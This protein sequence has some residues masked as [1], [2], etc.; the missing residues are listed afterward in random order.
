MD[1]ILSILLGL[2]CLLAAVTFIGHGIWVVVAAVVRQI[3]G[4]S[5]TQVELRHRKPCPQ[6]GA[7]H[8]LDRGKCTVCGAVPQVAPKSP[9]REEL[10]ATARQLKR[11]QTAGNIS[12]DQYEQLAAVLARELG[13]AATQQR[14]SRE[15]ADR[16]NTT[17][18]VPSAPQ[19]EEIIAA[20]VIDEPAPARAASVLAVGGAV[21]DTR[22]FARPST[23]GAATFGAGP[24][25]T[26][27]TENPLQHAAV[28]APAEP[29][30]PRPKL[31]D[32]LQ[33]F[34]EESNIRWG[35]ILAGFFIVVSSIGLVISLQSTL[36]RIPYFPALLFTGFTVAFHGAGLYT[37]KRWNLHAI[38]R[39]I[40]VISMLLVPLT[41]SA[42]VLMSRRTVDPTTSAPPI[43][44]WV[45]L[46]IGSA[47]LTWV[48]YT[49][50]RELVS[51]SKWRLTIGVI[52]C[53]LVQVLVHRLNL[54]SIDFWQ[55]TALGSLPLG[56]FLVASVGQ[57]ILARKW[58]S[59][60]WSRAQ[61]TFIVLGVS[62]FAFA[63]AMAMLL[64]KA[65]PRW[66]A[67]ARLTPIFSLAAGSATALG[68]LLHRRTTARVMAGVRTAGTVIWLLGGTT[69]LLMV[70]LAWP[71]P[72]LLLAVG[73]VNAVLLTTL[74]L[75]A[76]LSLLFAPAV[77]C[78]ALSALMGFH[79]AQGRFA[80]VPVDRI[81]RSVVEALL[82][83]RSSLILLVTA[84]SAT[85][86]AE[87]V[88]RFRSLHDARVILE[89]SG[90]L[91]ILGVLVALFAGFVPVSGWT[92]DRNFAAPLL[93]L[94]AGAFLAAAPF[95]RWPYLAYAG[96]AVLFAALVQGLVH[97][98][99]LREF[100]GERGWLPG[101]SLAAALVGHSLVSS[102]VLACSAL[103][104]RV[105]AAA[106]TSDDFNTRRNFIEP[107]AAGTVLSV[108]VVVPLLIVGGPTRLYES[109]ILA[110]LAALGWLAVAIV[111]RWKFA[112]SGL[113]AML[114][115]APALAIAAFCF[116]RLG[117]EWYRS[118]D[119]VGLQCLA[120]A[121]GA[122]T[123]AMTRRA[124]RKDSSF[125]EL[126]H[127]DWPSVDQIAIGG[128]TL[129]V[130]LLAWSLAI[131]SIGWELGF[132]SAPPLWVSDSGA[133]TVSPATWIAV[134]VMAVCIGLLASVVER[135]RL[136]SLLGF[137]IATFALV[138]GGA[139]PWDSAVAVAS[140]TRWWAGI[141][142]VVWAILFIS[143]SPLRS[144]ALSIG[145]LR[146]DPI[147]RPTAHAA[148]G[149]VPILFGALPILVLTI[150]PVAQSFQG[151]A[152]RGPEP[153]SFFSQIGPTA[154]YAVPLLAI[155]AVF[156]GY[157][158]RERESAFALAGSAVF[159]LAVNL[160]FIL[161]VTYAPAAAREVR[162][163]ECL[164]WNT[165]AAAGFAVVWLLLGA[166]MLPKGVIF[167]Q[168]LKGRRA[169]TLAGLQVILAA[170][171]ATVIVGWAAVSVIV[172]PQVTTSE[173]T[174]LGGLL[175][176]L[177]IG[178]ACAAAA[179]LVMLLQLHQR[180]QLTNLGF[181]LLTGGVALAA[182]TIDRYDSGRT[183]LAYHT[184]V[185]GWLGLLALA[186]VAVCLRARIQRVFSTREWISLG[187]V[188]QGIVTV[189]GLLL[190][191][192]AVR[193]N[194]AD[195]AQPWWSFAASVGVTTA[196]TIL[197]IRLCRQPYA[198][199][200]IAGAVLTVVLFW[201][202][203]VHAP[204]RS[205][206]GSEATPVFIEIVTLSLI[207]AAGFWQAVEIFVQVK[208]SRSLDLHF[209]GPR[210]HVAV[211]T[212]ALLLY[213]AWRVL[214]AAFGNEPGDTLSFYEVVASVAVVAL[215]ATLFSALWDR[216]SLL[217][218]PGLF[219]WLGIVALLAINLAGPHVPNFI[220]RI[221]LMVLSTGVVIAIAGQSWSYGANLSLIGVRLGVSDP[222]GGLKRTERW[223]PAIT[224]IAAAG[225]L[226]LSLPFVLNLPRDEIRIAVAF[227]PA[228]AAWG[229]ACLAD[230]ERRPMFRLQALLLA[231]VS[232][233]YLSWAQLGTEMSEAMWLTRVFRLLMV[234]S[235]LTFL[236]GLALP[237]WLLTAG[238]WHRVTR[239]A[240][241][242]AGAAAIA[243]FVAVLVLEIV[244][245]QPG[246]GAPVDYLQVLA[247]AVVLM[248]LIAGMISMALLPG[249]DPFLLSEKGKQAYVYAALATAALLFA[250]LYVCR[251]M[252]F[253]AGLLP[254]WPLIVMAIAFLGAGGGELFARYRLTVL[255]EPLTRVSSMLPL[256]P[257]LGMWIVA[258]KET[259]YALVLL[260]VGVLYLMLSVTQ[261]SWASL[262][263]AAVAANGALWSVLNRSGLELLSNPQLWIIPP[264]L[265]VLIAAHLNR[266]RLPPTALTSIRYA[267]VLLIYVSS[268]SE[269]FLRG[270]ATSLWPA[271]ILATLSVAGAFVGMML[272]IR[273][274]LYLGASFALISLITMVAH[275][276]Q[277]INH[278]WPW[279][280]FGVGMGIAILVLFGIFEKQREEVLKLIARLREW[281]Q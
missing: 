209:I 187:H 213:F 201:S 280:A 166:R 277:A 157:A 169:A 214:S 39:V 272:R 56:C 101:N 32:M 235:V 9:L 193:G 154:S 64:M 26:A 34:L 138:A 196:A 156:L 205:V 125:S 114:L 62:L 82:M 12:E 57:L 53:S 238:P 110:A 175:S 111:A 92:Q 188:A 119:H 256:L 172:E 253:D 22:E 48:A 58:Q 150:L 21:R 129:F 203:P 224:L 198:Y 273:A 254:Y 167:N 245:F 116:H 14:D 141:Y 94:Y 54:Q 252:W 174:V 146:W 91:A 171:G 120:V 223:L 231:G 123:W 33:G 108:L 126:F 128:A 178:L 153:G 85:A 87:V 260:V 160:A 17:V 229:L 80:D 159:Q 72:E 225:T 49:S 278:V 202:A 30:P 130:A 168:Q 218:L 140:A 29:V 89:T 137:A 243:A 7:A 219:G 6:C 266:R 228:A 264:A 86:V 185:G 204:W 51:V 200:S 44:F 122:A 127:A 234:L 102:A 109:T 263:A 77:L 215:G 208:R 67:A 276:A 38:S 104:R 240:G 207:V 222:V 43:L 135:V 27:A 230:D 236:Y 42:A 255:A 221:A 105:G 28:S 113:Q 37:L 262:L 265:S 61:P 145:W 75:A 251:P 18:S 216:R 23:A 40:L 269:I 10:L 261:R 155:V 241:Y 271:M 180:S 3:S 270:V 162:V 227:A 98:S 16:R 164:Q 144:S 24:F 217:A 189:L 161:Y 143:R 182:A 194:Y 199:A 149:A 115:V 274:F 170:L 195:P 13:T 121:V 179:R 66:L 81:G 134:L 106:S 242:L 74:A 132:E 226:I 60:S 59:I 220:D 69:M 2:V 103:R 52:G 163:A 133:T 90:C 79:V 84:I 4:A 71:Q 107:L 151:V 47:A 148:F 142:A 248:V 190:V 136:L 45:V 95:T 78:V 268:T 46:A 41:A 275:A 237:R 152:L 212:G 63:V 25:G 233:I 206:L 192:L 258:P 197:G 165:L 99:T 55:L 35:E 5:D 70:V 124:I 211:L 15:P 96:S 131:P 68:L 76:N 93:L 158:L 267:C 20:E 173:R 249:R 36:E 281:E 181:I 11:L 184:L 97:N 176:Y 247:I 177:S 65:E 88:R 83:G 232:A 246:V 117:A 50:S 257:V 250:H 210:S 147:D 8:G 191:V 259:D 118:L 244:L 73:L 31:S 239:Q 1:E 100:L 279:W 186:T 112:I 139:M 19:S 183:W